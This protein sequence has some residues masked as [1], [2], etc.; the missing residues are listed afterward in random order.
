MGR[1]HVVC[2]CNGTLFSLKRKEILTQASTWLN[3]DSVRSEISQSQKDKR[4]VRPRTR[5]ASSKTTRTERGGWLLG[6]APGCG[7]SFAG[8][9]ALWRWM[10]VTAAQ[11]SDCAQR[12]RTAPLE[13]GSGAK[14]CC[15]ASTAIKTEKKIWRL[16]AVG[17]L[18]SHLFCGFTHSSSPLGPSGACVQT[19][20]EPER[21]EW[22]LVWLG[23]HLVWL[24][25]LGSP[26]D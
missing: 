3:L 22:H 6:A 17:Y 25:W 9:K 8:R 2:K 12:R 13:A 19:A 10:V 24:G 7:A 5:A 11:Q 16:E 23:W 21:P 20:A 14:F 18:S 15:R 26:E 4:W 1:R